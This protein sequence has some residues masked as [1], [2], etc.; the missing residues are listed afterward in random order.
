MNDYKN[1]I[2]LGVAGNFAL[3]LEQAGESADFKDVITDDPNGPKGIFPFYLPNRSDFLGIYPLSSDTIVLPDKACNV[4]IEPEVA[5]VC[6]L[7]YDTHGNVMAI[8]PKFFGAYND[9]SLR[10]EGASKISHKKNWGACSKGLSKTL[11]PIDR[12]ESGGVMDSY[13]IASFLR[14]DGALM[15]YGEDVELTGYSYFYDTLIAWM[16]NQINT[17]QNTGPLEP[18]SQYLKDAGLPKQAI[19][20]IGATRYIHFGETNFLQENDEI[21]VVVYDN[22][23]YCMNPMLMMANSGKLDVDGVSALVQ[24]VVRA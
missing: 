9:C 14:R 7:T 10:I 23:R 5:L 6:D 22:N 13:R 11:I 18:V 4:Q 3:H 8:T 2:G 21:V 12:F 17:Q 20:S 19:I 15:R 24:K 1:F 16:I